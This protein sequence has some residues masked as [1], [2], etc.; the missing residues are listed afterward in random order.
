MQ[1]RGSVVRSASP[2]QVSEVQRKLDGCPQQGRGLH[3]V[4]LMAKNNLDY[5]RAPWYTVCGGIARSSRSAPRGGVRHCQRYAARNNLS[6]VGQTAGSGRVARD[7]GNCVHPSFRPSRGIRAC[8]SLHVQRSS[9]LRRIACLPCTIA[10]PTRWIA[11]ASISS[12]VPGACALQEERPRSRGKHHSA[13]C[14]RET[15]RARGLPWSL[16]C[17]LPCRHDLDADAR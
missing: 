1:T 12:E 2:A 15:Q 5:P 9:D 7:A 6:C 11:A 17:G 13:R 8:R 3:S 4:A 10:I 14:T 16:A